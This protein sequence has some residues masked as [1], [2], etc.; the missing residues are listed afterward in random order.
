M[1]TK[2]WGKYRTKIFIAVFTIFLVSLFMEVSSSAA[3][4]GT[5]AVVYTAMI[6]SSVSDHSGD[7]SKENPYNMFEDA[8]A[9]V[10]DGG[11]IYIL[12]QG[13]FIND[14]KN[15]IPFVI[16]KAVHIEPAE[17][18]TCASLE[19]RAAGIVIGA[20][21]TFSNIEFIFSNKYHAQI[22]ANGHSLTLNNVT[23]RQNARLVDVVAGGLYSLYGVQQGP[24]P[25][26][27]ARIFIQGEESEFG[28]IY[29]G[30]INGSYYGDVDIHVQNTKQKMSVN[31]YGCGAKEA[32]FDRD[33]FFSGEEPPSPSADPAAYTVGGRVNVKLEKT[34]IM[35]VDGAGASEGTEVTFNG[36]EYLADNLSLLNIDGLYVERGN[37]KPKALT[38][39]NGERINLAIAADSILNLSN[40]SDIAVNN[41]NGGGKLILGR[42]AVM[43]VSGELTGKTA[44]EVSGGYSGV[45]GVAIENH[46]YVK[47][48]PDTE[49]I[50]T[51]TPNYSQ[52]YL[53]FVK[54][55]NGNWIAVRNNM[56]T[57]EY[58]TDDIE[59]G[60]VSI[61][62]ETIDPKDGIPEGSIASE[63]E[64][65]RFQNWTDESGIIVGNDLHFIPQKTIS[66]VYEPM[67][68][69]ANF[70]ANAY[71][72]AFKANGGSGADMEEQDFVYGTE[73]KLSRNTYTFQNHTF[74]G[75][76][77]K[78]DGPIVYKDEASVKNVTSK[79]A[80]IVILYAKWTKASNDPVRTGWQMV[81]NKW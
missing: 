68:Y 43:D 10:S 70:A 30:S 75:W 65:Y 4:K 11:T 67:I 52:E 53:G 14:P 39:P 20:D 8:L 50:F 81:E 42:E 22:F 79:D 35:S 48:R 15:D 58:Q 19:S 71:K 47:S 16:D 34:F 25:G 60:G 33:D 78:P 51:F 74:A 72:I 80:E 61:E 29:A 41:F 5:K 64:G 1:K 44:F 9:N 73:Q 2:K 28:N 77:L 7:G 18:L 63:G 69:T 24:N 27:S 62:R 3:E 45:S 23:R 66:G 12:S 36:T 55:A 6:N 46:V 31:V 21:V 57:I 37:L 26:N 49:G 56:I 38:T 76:A 59:K 32:E 40:F 13:A 17:G 54:Q